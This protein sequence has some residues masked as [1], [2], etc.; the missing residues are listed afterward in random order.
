MSLDKILQLANITSTTT[1]NASITLTDVSVTVDD[2]AAQ[3]V[4][5]AREGMAELRAMLA[6]DDGEGDNDSDNDK[7]SDDGDDVTKSALYKRLIGKGVNPK[8]ARAMAMKAAKK[9]AATALCDGIMVALAGL[10]AA[11]GDWVELTSYDPLAYRLAASEA[12]PAPYGD[13]E[14]ADP[15]F[16]GKKRY[17]IDAKHIHAAIAYFSKP[18]NR[19]SYTAAQ[20]K[21]I[22]GKIRAAA[23]KHGVK[24]G[25]DSS[26]KVEASMFMEL[27]RSEQVMSAMNHGPM[28]GRHRHP[29][30]VQVVADEDHYHNNDNRHGDMG[31]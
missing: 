9:V 7:G 15:G 18:G 27:A 8:V 31:Y 19:A 14:Y 29:H 11:E 24:M 4:L 26:S 21:H 23:K 5:A 17:P 1:G 22:W 16:R 28:S 3:L 12:H 13:V 10:T 25:D 6:A 2:Q 20:V 30:H